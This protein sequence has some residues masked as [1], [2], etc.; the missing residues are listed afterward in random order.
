MVSRVESV[1]MNRV[2]FTAF[3]FFGGGGAVVSAIVNRPA[4]L[5]IGG[6]VGIYLLLDR[7]SVV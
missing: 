5:F 6:L 4:P 2:A 3:V 7:K 1:P